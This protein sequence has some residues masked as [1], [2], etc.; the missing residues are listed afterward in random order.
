M[1]VRRISKNAQER[2]FAILIQLLNIPRVND[3]AGQ[4]GGHLNALHGIEIEVLEEPGTLRFEG[5]L[6]DTT[7]AARLRLGRG[8]FG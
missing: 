6:L 3:A 1:N 7:T 5:G 2:C 8:R 4:V